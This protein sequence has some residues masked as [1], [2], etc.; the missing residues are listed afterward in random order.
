MT[1]IQVPY[2]VVQYRM[3]VQESFR[4]LT[5]NLSPAAATYPAYDLLRHAA[6]LSYSSDTPPFPQQQD[7]A[8]GTGANLVTNGAGANPRAP[9]VAPLT[10]SDATTSVGA[11][12]LSITPSPGFK[13]DEGTASLLFAV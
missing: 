13:N 8:P 10:F 4:P 11:S 2:E 9:D 1:I 5:T 6:C 7:M 3:W 12:D